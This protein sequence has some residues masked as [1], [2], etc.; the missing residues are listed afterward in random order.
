MT[1]IVSQ[2]CPSN[3][4]TSLHESIISEVPAHLEEASISPFPIGTFPVGGG[5]V[6][7][8]CDIHVVN[9]FSCC[10]GGGYTFEAL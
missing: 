7:Q 5:Y 6:P 8:P 10:V 9:V 2:Y 3:P 4:I 1:I